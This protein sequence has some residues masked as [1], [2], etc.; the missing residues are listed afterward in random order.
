MAGFIYPSLISCIVLHKEKKNI[1][2][3]IYSRMCTGK[4]HLDVEELRLLVACICKSAS[5]AFRDL[6]NQLQIKGEGVKVL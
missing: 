4:G 1:Y 5:L 2:I 6:E 3:Y